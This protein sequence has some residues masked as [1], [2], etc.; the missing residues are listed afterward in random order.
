MACLEV[1]SWRGVEVVVVV[2][3]S[4]V[5]AAAPVVGPRAVVGRCAVVL[6]RCAVLAAEGRRWLAYERRVLIAGATTSATKTTVLVVAHQT[7]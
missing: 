2:G 4:A 3:R 7:C 6:G 5:L 1:A